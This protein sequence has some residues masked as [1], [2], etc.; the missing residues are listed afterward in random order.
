MF[1]Y[2]SSLMSALAVIVMASAFT[3]STVQQASA[4]PKFVKV[5]KSKRIG[6]LSKWRKYKYAARIESRLRWDNKARKAYGTRY[7]SWK[8][9]KN[10]YKN[11][12]KNKK[13]TKWRCIRRG[14][15]CTLKLRRD[16]H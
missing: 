1:R 8:L 6:A 13:M 10:R 7:A 14:K 15:P 5:C 11:C 12:W 2:L 4:K 3:V 9:S 16:A